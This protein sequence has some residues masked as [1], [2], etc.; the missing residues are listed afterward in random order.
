MIDVLQTLEAAL[1]AASVYLLVGLGWNIVYSS[2]GYLNL[3]VG[4]FYVLAAILSFK[5][6]ATLGIDAPIVVA[7]A[8][9]VIVSSI[10]MISELALIRPLKHRGLEVLIVTAGLELILGEVNARLAPELAVRPE[11]FIAGPAFD[12]GGVLV[13]R[14]GTIVIATA[15]AAFCGLLWFFKRTDLGRTFRA[16]ADDRRAAG[17]IGINVPRVETIAFTLGVA[18]TALAAIVISPAQGVAA[19]GG[20]MIAIKSFLAVS[21]GGI[22]RY[23]G[24]VVGALAVALVEAFAARYWTTDVRDLLVLGGL[25]AALAYGG[26][27]ERGAWRDRTILRRRPAAP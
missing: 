21:I 4:G 5:L 25:I 12:I 13:P 2:C 15:V 16:V 3:A 18:F 14:Q 24:A 20:T 27:A 10:G 19:G 8:A 6:A 9:L 23:G 7:V 1:E 17:A 26:I 11:A 22:G